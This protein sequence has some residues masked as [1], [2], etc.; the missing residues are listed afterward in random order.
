MIVDFFGNEIKLD[1]V[2]VTGNGGRWE[3]SFSFWRVVKVN[4]KM[5]RVRKLGGKTKN[6]REETVYGREVILSSEEQ[7]VMHVLR[8]KQKERA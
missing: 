1:D 2:V 5:I 4:P 8:T 3:H 7:L 6:P